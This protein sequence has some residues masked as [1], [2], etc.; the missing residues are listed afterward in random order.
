[1]YVCCAYILR[2]IAC[3]YI[4]MQQPLLQ[5]Y[6][7]LTLYTLNHSNLL[8]EAIEQTTFSPVWEYKKIHH[9]PSVTPEFVNYLKGAIEMQI[10][11]TQHIEPPSV[12]IFIFY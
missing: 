2:S 7:K 3:T 1:M 9:I 11:V 8:T 5:Q 6:T 4:Y 10:H 12:S